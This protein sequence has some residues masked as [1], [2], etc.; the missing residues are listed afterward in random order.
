[1]TGID[2]K[3]G[4]SV[5]EENVTLFCKDHAL[6]DIMRQITHV[7]GFVWVRKG[8]EGTFTYELLQDVRSQIAEE[9]MRNH[10]RNAA[11][12]SLADAMEQYRPYLDKTQDQLKV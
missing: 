4:A 3:A 9:E 7:F 12:I 11:L 6:R 1:R 10:D 2:L 8:Q 5:A